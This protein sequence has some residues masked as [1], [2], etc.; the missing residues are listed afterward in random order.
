MTKI[1]D[2]IRVKNIAKI[3]VQCFDESDWKILETSLPGGNIIP[4]HDRLFRSR[5]FGDDDYPYCVAD[6]FDLLVAH[7]HNNLDEIEKYISN[8]CRSS[9]DVP[10]RNGT[11]LD[12]PTDADVQ[13]VC[14]V[15]IS[16]KT[17]HKDL[18]SELKDA[19]ASYGIESFVAHED[20]EVTAEWRLE[21]K[22]MLKTCDAFLYLASKESNKSWWCQ[23]EIGWAF[24]R[25]IPM[26]SVFIDSN[27]V[28]FLGAQQ[29][30]HTGDT[31]DPEKIAQAIFK[32]WVKD[33]QVSTAIVNGLIGKLASSKRFDDSDWYAKQLNVAPIITDEQAKRIE[34]AIV[35]N[36]QVRNANHE[37]LPNYL[38][39][40]ID[41]KSDE[42]HAG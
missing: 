34:A 7:D 6:V 9:F 26:F 4:E 38:R 12:T 32:T 35:G 8:T 42:K 11:D 22:K 31:F 21:L 1:D 16:H 15:F 37:T 41:A 14:H 2:A 24:G 33:E 30:L 20:I 40:L 39:E 36:D 27:P 25:D 13:G 17:E 28:A 19:L 18:A 23:Q 10:S 29:A 3:A 5:H